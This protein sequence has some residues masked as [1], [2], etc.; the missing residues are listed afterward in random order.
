MVGY[1]DTPG[2]GNPTHAFAYTATGGMQDLGTLG[3]VASYA[4]DI[5][6]S[7][8]IVGFANTAQGTIDGFL[9]SRNG[10]MV[11]LGPY[12][13]LCIN[14]AGQIAAVAGSGTQTSTY[15]SSGGTSAW[16]NIGSLGG[17]FTQPCAMNSRGEVVGGS[18]ITTANEIAQ[19]FLYSGGTITNLGTSGGQY[20]WAQGIN[21][22]GVVVGFAD[23]PGESVVGRL[24]LLRQWINREPERSYFGPAARIDNRRGDGDQ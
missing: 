2:T 8:Q 23:F 5:N 9:Y 22:S 17:S 24:C 19:P 15:I 14:D 12:Q 1:T 6:N 3:G 13:A 4:W 21:D 16:V 11:D 20:G 7:A 18:A 10:P